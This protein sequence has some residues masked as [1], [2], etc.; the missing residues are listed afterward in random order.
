MS[1]DDP[2]PAEDAT[3]HL[4]HDLRVVVD[5]TLV[6]GE[7]GGGDGPDRGASAAGQQHLQHDGLVD[8]R[9]LHLLIEDLNEAFVGG[10]HPRIIENR[11][12]GSLQ[13]DGDCDR[14]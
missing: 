8:V 7:D 14:N 12:T 10:C 1:F 3:W 4:F 13:M 2:V 9:H 11:P 5:L 6:V